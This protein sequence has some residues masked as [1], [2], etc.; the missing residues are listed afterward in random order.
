M[1]LKYVTQNHFVTRVNILFEAVYLCNSTKKMNF[2]F[3]REICIPE[4]TNSSLQS[5]RK[6]ILRLAL[7][8][9]AFYSGALSISVLKFL[10]SY[11][12]INLGIFSLP[13]VLFYHLVEIIVL[14][15]FS[16]SCWPMNFVFQILFLM[17][18]ISYI[19]LTLYIVIVDLT[20]EDYDCTK[21]INGKQKFFPGIIIEV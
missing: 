16:Y 14:F 7:A 11:N 2:D 8:N 15:C 10:Y 21:N 4:E 20:S 6:I 17:H 12:L 3:L 19:V 13:I 5:S 9:M 18:N 1:L